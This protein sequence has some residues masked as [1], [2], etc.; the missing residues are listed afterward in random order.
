MKRSASPR[1]IARGEAH[2]NFDVVSISS[3]AKMEDVPGANEPSKLPPLNPDSLN[4][5]EK[6]KSSNAAKSVPTDP[7]TFAEVWEEL[8][9]K[10]KKAILG[11]T[12][13]G[14]LSVMHIFNIAVAI[15]MLVLC[16][17]QVT[18]TENIFTGMSSALS[19]IYTIS[20]ALLLAA[21]ELRT[22][23]IDEAIRRQFGFMYNSYGRCLFLC[24]I[25]IFPFGMVGV[26]GVLVSLL[27]F[28]NAY[29]NFY[30]IT[31]H[32]SFSRGVPDYQP[33]VV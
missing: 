4:P 19:V 11:S 23:V 28:A 27:G 10:T 17:V 25:S 31:T 15:F 24:M 12:V 3:V 14:V 20:F 29:F 5:T 7:I 8:R 30:V 2:A 18:S 16:I 33:P 21:Y 26:Y 32:P 9:M 1:T 6:E 22:E 13:S